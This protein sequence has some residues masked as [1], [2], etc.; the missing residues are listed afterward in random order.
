MFATNIVWSHI[1]CYLLT[2]QWS[3]P[4]M[5][6]DTH[7]VPAK[8]VSLTNNMMGDDD[9]IM[10]GNCKSI[11][12]RNRFLCTRIVPTY[13]MEVITYAGLILCAFGNII[14]CIVTPCHVT[15]ANR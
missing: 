7:I 2:V 14:I 9:I 1:N 4:W 12:R 10:I 8:T 15:S 13:S 6:W 11:D 5:S 3:A